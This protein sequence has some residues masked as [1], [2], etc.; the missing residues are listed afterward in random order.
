MTRR[1]RFVIKTVATI[2]NDKFV[3]LPAFAVGTV[4]CESRSQ[5]N[6]D[7][8]ATRFEWLAAIIRVKA[9]VWKYK[10]DFK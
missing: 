8:K 6:H 9:I 4:I 5:F 2:T 3:N 10:E 7:L 1:N